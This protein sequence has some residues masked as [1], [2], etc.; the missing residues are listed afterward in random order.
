MEGTGSV[1]LSH[2]L[3]SLICQF[4]MTPNYPMKELASWVK[5]SSI[6]WGEMLYEL[7]KLQTQLEVE[8]H[9][10]R[11][12]GTVSSEHLLQHQ[13]WCFYCAQV[14]SYYRTLAK[15]PELEQHL[16]PLYCRH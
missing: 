9:A 5:S 3:R 1:S 8:A 13:Y 11:R 7:D 15:H 12:H 16:E 10:L 14:R 2:I 6:P 4:R